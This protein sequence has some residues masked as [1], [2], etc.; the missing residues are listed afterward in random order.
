MENYNNG[1]KFSVCEN[2]IKVKRLANRAQAIWKTSHREHWKQLV[3]PTTD[4][5]RWNTL[6]TESQLVWIFLR[7]AEKFELIR[8]INAFMQNRSRLFLKHK[9]KPLHC[10]LLT[11]RSGSFLKWYTLQRC[12]TFSSN[13]G[14]SFLVVVSGQMVSCEVEELSAGMKVCFPFESNTKTSMI[15][16]WGGILLRTTE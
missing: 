14:W 7:L 10:Q 4:P 8:N 16:E 3:Q 11:W 15:G 5:K 13:V 2:K 9:W 6:A 12:C 1:F